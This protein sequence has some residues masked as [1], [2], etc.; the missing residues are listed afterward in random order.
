MQ[1]IL[2]VEKSIFSL[3][4]D[5]ILISFPVPRPLYHTHFSSDAGAAWR[6]GAEQFERRITLKVLIFVTL[7]RAALIL[8]HYY[9]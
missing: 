7:I 9:F 2:L 1:S 4:C 6:D 5:L 8:R 3:P